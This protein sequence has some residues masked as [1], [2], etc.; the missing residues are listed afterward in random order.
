MDVLF[1]LLNLILFN[2]LLRN[3]KL[4]SKPRILAALCNIF[5]SGCLNFSLPFLV[6]I[7]LELIYIYNIII[8]YIN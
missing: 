6:F 8:I 1:T 2:P 5:N 3:L 4:L 7:F